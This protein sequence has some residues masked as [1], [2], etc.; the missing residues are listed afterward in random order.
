MCWSVWGE[1]K[2]VPL[3]HRVC[4]RWS[5]L[6][7]VASA[8]CGVQGK[9]VNG[10]KEK[11][12]VS[13]QTKHRVTRGSETD[14]RQYNQIKHHGLVLYA[15][16]STTSSKMADKKWMLNSYFQVLWNLLDRATQGCLMFIP[17]LVFEKCWQL[18]WE[19]PHTDTLKQLWT[20][21]LF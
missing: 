16:I 4:Q 14:H 19:E 20:V 13:E 5:T 8:H 6:F 11:E 10:Q 2:P 18:L 12:A 17:L 1:G 7:L 21:K 3:F 15:E 9:P